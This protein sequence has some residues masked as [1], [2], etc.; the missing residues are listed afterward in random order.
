MICMISSCY[1]VGALQSAL[2]RNY[3]I[4]WISTVQILPRH[5]VAADDNLDY[6]YPD[7]SDLSVRLV[8]AIDASCGQSG[9]QTTGL[10]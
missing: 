2:A 4:G 9:D 7:L 8:E 3:F 6:L 10:K 5:L 1:R